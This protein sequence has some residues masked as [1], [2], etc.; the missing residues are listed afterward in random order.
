MKQILNLMLFYPIDFTGGDER[1]NKMFENNQEFL[2]AL[3]EQSSG[4]GGLFEKVQLTIDIAKDKIHD[5]VLSASKIHISPTINN[6]IKIEL[7]ECDEISFTYEHSF[8][9]TL[10]TSEFVFNSLFA[11]KEDEQTQQRCRNC[12]KMILSMVKPAM[13]YH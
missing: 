7:F 4:L 9:E 6:S 12:L 8:D 1:I 11:F 2:S 5:I 10:D 13:S 3:Q